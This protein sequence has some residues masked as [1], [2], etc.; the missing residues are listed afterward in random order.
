MWNR[1]TFRISILRNEF[2]ISTV[3]GCQPVQPV[4]SYRIQD[5]SGVGPIR[6]SKTLTN[7]KQRT[8]VAGEQHSIE[9]EVKA[10]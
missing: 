5:N 1:G 9:V 4:D 3:R 2:A 8:S 7:P 6:N 10:R